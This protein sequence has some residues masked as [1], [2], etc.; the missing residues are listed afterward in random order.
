[1]AHKIRHARED[2]LQSLVKQG[3]LKEAKIGKPEFCEYCVIG[4]HIR[5]KFDNSS[6]D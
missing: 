3:L 4:K 1:M 5:V 2:A 6:S